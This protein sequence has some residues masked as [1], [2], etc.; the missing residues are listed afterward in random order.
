M[1]SKKRGIDLVDEFINYL[2]PSFVQGMDHIRSKSMQATLFSSM[3][4]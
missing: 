1:S 2:D 4:Q 3:T